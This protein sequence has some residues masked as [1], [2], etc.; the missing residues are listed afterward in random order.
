MH[1]DEVYCFKRRPPITLIFNNHIS[2]SFEDRSYKRHRLINISIII[3][4]YDTQVYRW[5]IPRPSLTSLKLENAS[6]KSQ[7][8]SST[9]PNQLSIKVNYSEINNATEVYY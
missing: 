4:Y 6:D 1:R 8:D 3:N 2:R 5:S 9:S 7:P